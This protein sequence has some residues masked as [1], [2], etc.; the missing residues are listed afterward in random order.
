MSATGITIW[1]VRSLPDPLASLA[2]QE[3]GARALLK[4]NGIGDSDGK[5]NQISEEGS[6]EQAFR[7]KRLPRFRITLHTLV[8]LIIHQFHRGLQDPV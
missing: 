4:S 7:S 6:A 1:N 2:N 3:T 8:R 5:R